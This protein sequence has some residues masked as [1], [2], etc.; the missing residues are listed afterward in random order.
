MSYSNQRPPEAPL[1]NTCKVIEGGDDDR[2]FIPCPAGQQSLGLLKIKN[3]VIDKGFGIKD[4][5]RFVLR[6][7][8][9]PEA[10]VCVETSAAIGHNSHLYKLV[11]GM[12]GGQLS[13]EIAHDHDHF[14]NYMQQ[15]KDRWFLATVT[16]REWTSPEGKVI[17]FT[18]VANKSLMPHPDGLKWG[19]ASGYFKKLI[20]TGG[21]TSVSSAQQ[22]LPAASEPSGFEDYPDNKAKPIQVDRPLG[23]FVYKPILS[24]DKAKRDGQLVFIESKKG[25]HNEFNPGN[26]HFPEK[27]KEL[28]KYFIGEVEP[29]PVTDVDDVMDGDNL[30]WE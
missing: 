28:E 15:F 22:S 8:E 1:R 23:R 29:E 2:D 19:P 11:F 4:G 25:Q 7:K 21:K 9:H 14:F 5:F 6:S 12:S 27:V 24:A 26:Y 3:T 18:D 20:D 10:F 16:Q 13:S 17:I 30:A